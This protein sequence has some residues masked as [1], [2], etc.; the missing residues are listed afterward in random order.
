MAL[1]VLWLRQLED[2]VFLPNGPVFVQL[3]ETLQNFSYQ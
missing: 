3:R 1:P 2:E